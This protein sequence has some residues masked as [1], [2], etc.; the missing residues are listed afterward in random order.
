MPIIYQPA[1]LRDPEKPSEKAK[2]AIAI[3]NQDPERYRREHRQ[4]V[5][6]EQNAAKLKTVVFAPPDVDLLQS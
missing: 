3:F 4:R 5:I 1:K 6:Q 2:T